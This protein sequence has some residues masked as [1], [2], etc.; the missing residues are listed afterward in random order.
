MTQPAL[1]QQSTA[2]CLFCPQYVSET[3]HKLSLIGSDDGETWFSV[4][5]FCDGPG[6]TNIHFDFSPKG[7][8][9][10]ATATW[11]KENGIVRLVWGDGNTWVLQAATFDSNL[12]PDVSTRTAFEA[13]AGFW[14]PLAGVLTSNA[15]FM[16]PFTAVLGR[17][18]AKSLGAL[19]PL[20]VAM[21]VLSS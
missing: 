11:T 15:L 12:V 6:M 2:L 4:S 5:G 7:G 18:R 10:D 16:A 20:P 14:F 13:A 1:P 17:V 9:A 19:N 3:E 21:T 8:P